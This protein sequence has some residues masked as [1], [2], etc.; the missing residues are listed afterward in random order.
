MPLEC[1]GEFGYAAPL[2]AI[3][4]ERRKKTRVRFTLV[5]LYREKRTVRLSSGR[6]ISPSYLLFRQRLPARRQ[7]ALTH[8]IEQAAYGFILS[9]RLR[10]H[11]V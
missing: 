8:L 2:R 7:T 5:S 11:E 6:W 10:L 4:E 1:I 9:V 3:R